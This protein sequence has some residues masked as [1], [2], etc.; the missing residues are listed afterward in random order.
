MAPDRIDELLDEALHTGSVPAE[1]TPSER[2]EITRLL[3]AAADLRASADSVDIEVERA[4]PIARARFE[5]HLA[6][7]R[8]P[9][10][11]PAPLR[12]GMW[13]RLRDR[14]RTGPLVAFGSAAAIA[15]VALV[16]V[17]VVPSLFSGTQSAYASVLTA[18]DYA[19]VE[20]VVTD[21][22][23]D[24]AQRTVIVESEFGSL[25]VQLPE[26]TSVVSDAEPLTVD[27]IVKGQRV[28][29]SGVVDKQRRLAAST[30]V[31][32]GATS[33]PDRK[34]FERLRDVHEPVRGTIV[35]FS[36]A[37]DGSH[38]VVA[39]LTADGGRFFAEVDGP[40]VADLLNQHA[41]VP[42][43]EIV[44]SASGDDRRPGVLALEVVERRP[45][46]PAGEPARACETLPPVRHGLV[47]VC[48]V[49][50]A[51]DGET[52]TIETAADGQRIA[53]ATSKT[54]VIPLGESDVSFEQ[55]RRNPEAGIGHL[56]VIT[57]APHRDSDRIVADVILVGP[58]IPQPVR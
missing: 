46:P 11:V 19:Q 48:G 22:V 16:A 3:A 41:S 20:G 13:G 7:A 49:L 42:G 4:L 34:H 35:W 55:L 43:A 27:A 50:I 1:A 37:E 12:R 23:S 6:A 53:I 25:E 38:G 28:R 10:V 18:G 2:A 32:S 40:A 56:V 21:V 5:R 45:P 47:R 52:L 26:G 15:I 36:H 9:A 30:V 51:R 24:G 17:L 33:K 54:R 14:L 39:L 44:L 31:V 58:P 29:V 57:G 8:G